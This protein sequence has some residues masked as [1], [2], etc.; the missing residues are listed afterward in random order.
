MQNNGDD[1][2][3]S[4]TAIYEAVEILS[5]DIP[6]SQVLPIQIKQEKNLF[7][8]PKFFFNFFSHSFY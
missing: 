8:V 7:N 3:I 6:S 2:F 1:V 5:V 4:L